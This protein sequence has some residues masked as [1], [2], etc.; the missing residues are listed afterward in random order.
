VAALS[1]G[2]KAYAALGNCPSGTNHTNLVAPL[3]TSGNL[4]SCN[5]NSVSVIDAVALKERTTIPVG[6]GAVS[7]DVAGDASRVFAVAAHDGKISIIKTASDTV[8]TT[9]PAPQQDPACTGSCPVQIPFM[10]RVFP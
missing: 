7:L 1:D 8:T 9:F 3:P 4:A 10:V 2:S 6:S 5:G